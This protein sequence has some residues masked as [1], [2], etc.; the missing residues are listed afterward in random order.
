MTKSPIL[1]AFAATASLLAGP[2]MAQYMPRQNQYDWQQMQREEELRARQSQRLMQQQQ[3]QQ[4]QYEDEMYKPFP[5]GNTYT[6][7][8]APRR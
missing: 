5:G 4:R 8:Y 6:N 7:P 1:F 2:A 3:R